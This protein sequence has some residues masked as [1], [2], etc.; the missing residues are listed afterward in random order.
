MLSVLINTDVFRYSHAQLIHM[1]KQ[2][3]TIEK[4]TLAGGG[5]TIVFDT[6]VFYMFVCG[7]YL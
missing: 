7:L 2:L 1:Y 4:S 6:I 3:H 5:C